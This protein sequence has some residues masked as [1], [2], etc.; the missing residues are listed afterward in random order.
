MEAINEGRALGNEEISGSAAKDSLKQG[1]DDSGIKEAVG[2]VEDDVERRS[3]VDG[4]G[5]DVE[6]E[7][8]CGIILELQA[9]GIA[10][11]Q[12]AAERNLPGFYIR[13]VK[14]WRW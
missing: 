13:R 11:T 4:G 5:G 2:V 3:E 7:V 12:E 1:G 8:V 14:K 10:T 6:A 9:H